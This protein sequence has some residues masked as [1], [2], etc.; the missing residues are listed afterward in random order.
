MTQR[1][2]E[3]DPWVR[4]VLEKEMATH[5]STLARRSPRTEEPGK[6]Q[7]I[8][9]QRAGHNCS[10]LVCMHACGQAA[11]LEIWDLGIIGSRRLRNACRTLAQPLELSEEKLRSKE[12]EEDVINVTQKMFLTPTGLTLGLQNDFAHYHLISSSFFLPYL[13]KWHS[14]RNWFA[15]TL[16]A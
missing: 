3:F 15:V 10:S 1:R 13:F 2:R 12:I 9:S 14:S 6:L 4:K 11:G 7:S 8:G 16:L 5:S